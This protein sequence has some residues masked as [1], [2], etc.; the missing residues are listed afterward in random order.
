MFSRRVKSRREWEKHSEYEYVYSARDTYRWDTVK[1]HG[2]TVGYRGKWF[3][4]PNI[5]GKCFTVLFIVCPG[6]GIVRLVTLSWF[7]SKCVV[8][9]TACC[10]P[11]AVLSLFRLVAAV[12]Q[13]H[14]FRFAWVMPNLPSP[15]K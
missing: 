12:D 4:V 14:G 7:F 6:Q 8:F 5:V 11:V 13:M 9:S 1:G 15:P 2:D 10:L 3:R